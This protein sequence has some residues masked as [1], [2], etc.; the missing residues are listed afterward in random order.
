MQQFERHTLTAI[1]LLSTLTLTLSGCASHVVTQEHLN[2]RSSV[3]LGL[4]ASEF[5][6]SDRVD[7][8]VSTRYRVRTQDG[9]TFNCTIGGSFSV[10]GP[11]VTDAICHTF[12]KSAS[13]SDQQAPGCNALLKAAG[14]C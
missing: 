5:T 4:E 12:G 2:Q 11:I 8:A 14:Q 1:A 13:S 6:I 3:A 10:T 7:D 9:R